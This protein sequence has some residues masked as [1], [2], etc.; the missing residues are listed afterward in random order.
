MIA[1]ILAA[2]RGSRLRE[3]TARK[4]KCL[5]EIAGK[6]LLRW[7][8]EALRKA[9]ARRLL[10]VRGYLAQSLTPQAA[11]LEAGSFETVENLRW[12]RSNMLSSL[13]CAGP[14]LEKAFAQGENEATI[15]YS[16]IVYPAQHVRALSACAEPL[17]I[18]Y[19]LCWEQLWR[20]RF[21]DPLLDAETF[22]QTGGL[23]REIGGKPQ[24][25][26]EI[27]GQYLGLI[28]VTPPG[29]RVIREACAELGEAVAQTDMT[30]FLRRLIGKG[31]NVGAVPVQGRWCEVDSQEDLHYYEQALSRGAW[32][33]DWRLESKAISH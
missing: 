14:W 17:A 9:G 8:C 20:L 5:V 7:Q 15:S 4:P 2:G 26:A 27:Q 22:R 30:G 3:L 16:D 24:S 21:G 11:G 25:L 28:R 10:A 29:W 6:P 31:V 12:E 1:V 33:H 13:L 19:D 23:L 32:P 18:A